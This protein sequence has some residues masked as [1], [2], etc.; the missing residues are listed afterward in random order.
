M[1]NWNF[2][3]AQNVMAIMNIARIIYLPISTGK[4]ADD[5]CGISEGCA[6][7]FDMLLLLLGKHE[8]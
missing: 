4:G 2:G 6:A 1:R 3:S 8:E 5:R 7:A